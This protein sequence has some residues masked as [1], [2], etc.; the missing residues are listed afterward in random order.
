[1]RAEPADGKAAQADATSTDALLARLVEVAERKGVNLCTLFRFF[2]LDSSGSLS[3]EEFK[4]GMFSLAKVEAQA[5]FTEDEMDR[6]IAWFDTKGDGNVSYEQFFNRASVTDPALGKLIDLDNKSE[7]LRVAIEREPDTKKRKDLT[8]KLE[9]AEMKKDAINMG[10]EYR[11]GAGPSMPPAA[12][13]LR[14]T[15]SEPARSRS[16]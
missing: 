8:R 12:P 3:A 9:N 11:Y 7:R 1:M 16:T 13:P 5:I 14:K 6:M 2:D 4:V 15:R 10:A